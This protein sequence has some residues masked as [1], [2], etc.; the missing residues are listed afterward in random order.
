MGISPRHFLAPLLG[1]I[2][3]LAAA[4][5]PAGWA[6]PWAGGGTPWYGGTPSTWS[7]GS[8]PAL[9]WG[10]GSARPTVPA[11]N[12]FT[13]GVN[14]FNGYNNGLGYG[15]PFAGS[16]PWGSGFSPWGG[17][18]SPWGGGGFPWGSGMSP[19]SFMSPFGGGSPWGARPWGF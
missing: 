3:V 5:S 6:S 10:T 7:G 15:Y 19:Y 1:A 16:N 2:A 13:T 9:D 11:M 8:V 4:P 17:G 12:P 18:G 14:P